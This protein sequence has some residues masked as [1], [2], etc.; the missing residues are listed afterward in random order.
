M[1]ELK[2]QHILTLIELLIRGARYN[3][4]AMTTEKL[5]KTINRS[6]QAASKHLL[7]LENDGCVH[8]VRKGRGFRVKVTEKGGEQ[9][10]KLYTSLKSALDSDLVR[11]EFN[12]VAISGMG[13]GAYYMS[14]RFYKRQFMKRLGFEPYPG[15]LNVKLSEQVYVNAK[16]EL[17]NHHSILIDGFNNGKRSYGWVKC[18]P[19]RINNSING[20][21]LLL[22]RTHHDYDIIEVIAPVKIKDSI[23]IT[24][25]DRVNVT[26]KIL[27]NAQS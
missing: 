10:S 3:Y 25:G 24:D 17:D 20:A 26:V 11:L 23:G 13:E 8:R 2:L 22:E 15:T 7:D 16:K 27:G 19:A 12:G 5:G 18:Y 6:Q 9:M 21:L 14:Q 4:I 1:P